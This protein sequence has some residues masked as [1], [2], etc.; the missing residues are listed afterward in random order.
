MRGWTYLE[1]LSRCHIII[2]QI[3]MVA[4]EGGRV[5]EMV[6]AAKMSKPIGTATRNAIYQTDINSRMADIK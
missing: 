3:Q 1:L 6:G 5:A 4:E 2:S